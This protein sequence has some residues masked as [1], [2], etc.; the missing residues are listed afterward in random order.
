M[1]CNYKL[2]FKKIKFVKGNRIF[3][4]GMNKHLI[5]NIHQYIVMDCKYI[6]E[7]KKTKRLY[8]LTN[9]LV[10]YHKKVLSYV[11]FDS[12]NILHGYFCYRKLT[13]IKDHHTGWTIN[14]I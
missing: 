3:S 4:R 5:N 11:Y 6:D 14:I 8:T 7:L 1:S 10:F 2:I 13:Y 12:K 9:Q